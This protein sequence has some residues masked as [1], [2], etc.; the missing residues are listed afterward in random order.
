MHWNSYE[1]LGTRVMVE[2]SHYGEAVACC[3]DVARSRQSQA[4]EPSPSEPKAPGGPGASRGPETWQSTPAPGPPRARELGSL[5]SAVLEA[6]ALSEIMGIP[7]K[8]S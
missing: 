4:T 6:G 5:N 3:E 7:R 1:F 8:D 2:I